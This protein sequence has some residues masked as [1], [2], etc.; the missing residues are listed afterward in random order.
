MNNGNRILP[1]P[2]T[3]SPLDW[4]PLI[5]GLM[6]AIAMLEGARSRISVK[7]D[8][9]AFGR[10]TQNVLVEVN[11]VHVSCMY[12]SDSNACVSA[13]NSSGRPPAV[14]WLGNS[15]LAAIN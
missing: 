6:L 7:L 9:A 13:Y 10:D 1:Q 11:G 4:L 5:L 8:E 14:L 2:R 3:T 12:A 15:Q